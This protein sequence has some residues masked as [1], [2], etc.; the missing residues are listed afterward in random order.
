[1]NGGANWVKGK[2]VSPHPFSV[3]AICWV[4]V[5]RDWLA[6]ALSA[7]RWRGAHLASPNGHVGGEAQ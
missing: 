5:F 4:A 7:E 2:Q 3:A 1:M 6:R